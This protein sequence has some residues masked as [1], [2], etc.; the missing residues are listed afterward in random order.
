VAG[1]EALQLDPAC[2]GIV[3][4]LE[5]GK[6]VIAIIPE[7]AAKVFKFGYGLNGGVVDGE[8]CGKDCWVLLL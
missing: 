1:E 7:P 3:D 8:A 5:D 2:F 4:V 6:V